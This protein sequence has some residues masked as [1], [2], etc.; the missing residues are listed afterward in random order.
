MAGNDSRSRRATKAAASKGAAVVAR[1]TVGNV[2]DRVVARTAGVKGI[3]DVASRPTSLRT[4]ARAGARTGISLALNSVA[5]VIGSRAEDVINRIGYKRL[6]IA[7]VTVFALGMSMM[8]ALVIGAVAAVDTVMKPTAV[9][10]T[11]MDMIPGLGDNEEG[12]T[13]DDIRELGRLCGPV[14]SPEQVLT[15]GEDPNSAATFTPAAVIDDNGKATPA[16]TEAM[17]LIPPDA[18]PLLAETWMVYRFSH[19]DTDPHRGWEEFEQVYAPAHS[20]V[21]AHRGE[22]RG[23]ITPGEL[24]MN[25]DP[26]GI[27]PP[28]YLAAASSVSYLIMEEWF[29]N[30]TEVQKSA[31]LGRAVSLCGI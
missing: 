27:Y 23:D 29:D 31:V 9:V 13:Q 7:V 16:V 5:P 10:T 2:A 20:L 12:Y 26:Y 11:V 3:G 21:S 17:R 24:L 19:P 25:I 8:G 4:W 18:D 6:V 14:P 1:K 22:T 28:F 30:I 15:E